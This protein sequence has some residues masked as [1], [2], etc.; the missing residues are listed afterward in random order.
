[1]SEAGELILGKIGFNLV[2]VGRRRVGFV[3]V[4][5][6]EGTGEQAPEEIDGE[7]GEGKGEGVVAVD[8]EEAE[9]HDEE[10][11]PDAE[12][13]DADRERDEHVDHGEDGAE[14]EQGR[15]EMEGP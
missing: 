10:A 2:D 14:G 7:E 11:F 12:T 5:E 1:M 8:V 15:I 6:I 9:K 3:T 4:E 13:G